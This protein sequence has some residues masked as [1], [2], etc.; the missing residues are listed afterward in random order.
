MVEVNI[1]K[2]YSAD[3]KFEAAHLLGKLVCFSDSL[4]DIGRYISRFNGFNG[5]EHSD[6]PFMLS[7]ETSI[8]VVHKY[9]AEIEI[10][11]TIEIASSKKQ[12]ASQEPIWD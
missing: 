7:C 8:G 11:D 2:I 1:I 3:N 12:A 9:I 5:L 6:F 10:T 4:D